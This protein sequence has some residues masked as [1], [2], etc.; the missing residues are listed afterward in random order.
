MDLLNLYLALISVVGLLLIVAGLIHLPRRAQP[1]IF[2]CLLGLVVLIYRAVTLFAID[3][4]AAAVHPLLY[5][6]SLS[7]QGFLA[8]VVVAM[9]AYI[10]LWLSR[11]RSEA[12]SSG[13]GRNQLLLNL[14]VSSVAMLLAALIFNST[15]TLLGVDSLAGQV[16]PWLA[17]AVVGQQARSW[18]WLIALYWRSGPRPAGVRLGDNFWAL[19]IH[20]LVMSLGGGL[21]ALAL[22][23]FDL[24]GMSIFF[25]PVLLAAY[26]FHL[27]VERNAQQRLDLEQIIARRTQELV[28]ANKELAALHKDKDAFLAILAHD[29][30]SPLNSIRLSSALLQDRAAVGEDEWLFLMEAIQQSEK[31]LSEMVDNLLEIEYLQSGALTLEPEE[32]DL[33]A[34]VAEV[35]T[36]LQTHAQAKSIVL[37]QS[38]IPLPFPLYADRRRL[39]QVV[40]NLVSNAIKYT[41]DNSLVTIQARATEGLAFIEV[42]DTGYGI[43]ADEL[44][45]I[46][47]RFYRARKHKDKAAGTGLGLTIVQD[48]VK[49]HHGEVLVTSQEGVGSTFQVRLPLRFTAETQRPT[50]PVVPVELTRPVSRRSVSVALPQSLQTG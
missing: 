13:S 26:A 11:S 8:A 21:L 3:P 12:P 42:T 27:Y 20:L 5:P 47:D 23:E 28:T 41:P 30:R 50:T 4:Y 45:R 38:L 22:R 15:Q 35:L 2:V 29:M 48:I 34:L 6:Q 32:F 33:S 16:G 31:T 7:F 17:A 19:P 37:K 10:G 49:A 18:L 39:Q 14:G 25:L 24:L 43:P 40:S 36:S 1:F 44:P 9:A 46:F